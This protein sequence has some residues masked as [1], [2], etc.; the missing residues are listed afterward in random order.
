MVTAGADVALE[1]RLLG[2]VEDVAGRAQEDHDV[3]VGEV[4]VG[5]RGGV[6]G[7]VDLEPVLRR[8][9]GDGD[10]ALRDAL[11][12]PEGRGLGEDQG[13]EALP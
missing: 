1:R 11:G 4:R 8:H 3:V 7:R 9:L 2:V 10:G 13:A 12:V 6:L 5:E